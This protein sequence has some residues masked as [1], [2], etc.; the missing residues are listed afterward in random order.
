MRTLNKI[1]M[2]IYRYA[3]TYPTNEWYDDNWNLSFVVTHEHRFKRY[4]VCPAWERQNWV[5]HVKSRNFDLYAVITQK[6]R[7]IRPRIDPQIESCTAAFWTG[8]L[9]SIFE[10]KSSFCSISCNNHF[11]LV[12]D[13]PVGVLVNILRSITIGCTSTCAQN[14]NSRSTTTAIIFDLGTGCT[15]NSVRLATE[16]SA[17]HVAAAK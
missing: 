16:L 3:H 1:R 10:R 9:T 5:P 14:S 17:I 13:N 11:V 7:E 2:M 4:S 6:R 8:S 12:D 15:I